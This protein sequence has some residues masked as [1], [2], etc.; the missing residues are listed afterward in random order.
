[1]K[2]EER[3]MSKEEKKTKGILITGTDTGIGK[4]HVACLLAK[5]FL[6]LGIQGVGV[7]KPIETGVIDVPQDALKLKESAECCE[8][9]SVVAPYTFKEPVSPW[10]ASRKENRPIS[11]SV[12]EQ[13]YEKICSKHSLTIV[14]TAGGLFVPISSEGTYADLAKRLHL[15]IVVVVGLRLGAI[16]HTLLTIQAARSQGLQVLGYVLN[17]YEPADSAGARSVEEAL[18]EFA[19][20]PLLGTIAYGEFSLN[21]GREIAEKILFAFA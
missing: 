15:P 14:E 16:N 21:K 17:E 2:A 9:V 1:M 20:V 5:A 8:P 7:F 18:Q 12:L 10:I 11:F 19:G 3:V 6:S 13:T 4:T